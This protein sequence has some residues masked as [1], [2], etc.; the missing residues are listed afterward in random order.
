MV[1]GLYCNA[2]KLCQSAKVVG[3][4]HILVLITSILCCGL[5]LSDYFGCYD[6]LSIEFN[7]IGLN[8]IYCKSHVNS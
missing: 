8:M 6:R 1:F 4:K 3:T 2:H 7:F 5:L